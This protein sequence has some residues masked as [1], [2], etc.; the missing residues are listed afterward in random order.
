MSND[1]RLVYVALGGAGEIGMNMYA[2]G[3]GK[4]GAERWILVDMGVTFPNMDGSPGVDLITADPG[5]IAERRDRL[6]AIFI[7]HGHEDHV[8]ALGMLW[9]RVETPVYCRAFTGLVARDKMERYGLD[10]SHLLREH[11]RPRAHV[12]AGPGRDAHH[13]GHAAPA[14]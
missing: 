1:E 14:H 10:P 7:T 5:F 13:Y 9:H 2:Y 11:Q 8:G 4:P 12:L 3:W 6:E